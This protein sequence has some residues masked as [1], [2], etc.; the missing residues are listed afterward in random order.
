[1]SPLRSVGGDL[2]EHA[3][4]AIVRSGACSSACARTAHPVLAAHAAP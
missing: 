1:L 2:D 3:H 4:R